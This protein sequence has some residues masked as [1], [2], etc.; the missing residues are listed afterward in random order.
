[1]NINNLD[2]SKKYILGCSYGPDS[3]ALFDMLIKND[4]DFIVCHCNY[5][6]REESNFEENSLLS[7]CKDKNI[8]CFVKEAYYEKE[9]GNME[10]WA[11]NVRYKFFDDISKKELRNNIL[12]A[13]NQDDLIETYILQIKRNNVVSYYGLNP[14][15]FKNELH[16]IRPL[17]NFTKKELKGYCDKNNV[18]YS[19]DKTNNENICLRN[20]IRNNYVAK[21]TKFERDEYINEIKLKNLE[22]EKLVNSIQKLYEKLIIF[23]EDIMEL[24]IEEF[25]VLLI[26][27]LK[28]LDAYH[29]ISD[30]FTF[31][32]YEKIKNDKKIDYVNDNFRIFYSYGQFLL[33]R[34]IAASYSYFFDSLEQGDIFELNKNSKEYNNI[35]DKAVYIKNVSKDDYIEVLNGKKKVSRLFIDQKMPAYLREIWP[36]VYDNENK[37]IYTPHYHKNYEGEGESPINFNINNLI[38]T[39]LLYK[40]K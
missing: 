38:I 29:P 35:K 23:K 30:K 33:C 18:P 6:L 22:N 12:I 4:I 16:I 13:H 25:H 20:R 19:I 14:D 21:L 37:L 34:P 3:M 17:L 8:V 36:G 27:K 32:I 7:Y 15:Y 2:K 40:I 24:T 11:R 5:H 39:F 1:M 28:D 26:K 31:E 9:D 10:E